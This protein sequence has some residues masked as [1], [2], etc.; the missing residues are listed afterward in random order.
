MLFPPPITSEIARCAHWADRLIR[1]ELI[2]G[3]IATENDYTSNFIGALRREINARSIRGLTAVIKV[4][5]PTQERLLGADG[6]VILQN[7]TEFKAGIFEAKW[8]RL[9]THTNCWDSIQQSSRLSHF[10][11]QLLRQASAS[12][13]LAI[14]EMFYSEHPFQSQSQ[15]FPPFGSACVWHAKAIQVSN[16]RSNRS[17]PWTD[18]ELLGLLSNNYNDIKQVFE[19]ICNCSEGVK[20]PNSNIAQAFGDLGVPHKALVI[21]YNPTGE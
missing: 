16:A 15:H 4:L 8:P 1:S 10:D 6:C 3:I 19:A 12:R 5:N 14:W 21:N 13:Y 11:S 2:Q 17:T 20:M 9:T 18:P 7:T